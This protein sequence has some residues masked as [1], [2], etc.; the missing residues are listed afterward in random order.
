MFLSKIK[1]CVNL[2]K[3]CTIIILIVLLYYTINYIV[4]TIL[5]FVKLKLNFEYSI[6]QAKSA[7][8]VP[9]NWL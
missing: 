1:K 7:A 6:F 3:F 4:Y 8:V 5:I 2:I 9:K